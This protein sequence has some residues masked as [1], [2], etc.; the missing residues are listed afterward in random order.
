MLLH[1]SLLLHIANLVQEARDRILQASHIIMHGSPRGVETPL[2]IVSC[3][4]VFALIKAALSDYALR[5]I[6]LNPAGGMPVQ[7]ISLYVLA[8]R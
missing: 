5:A 7:Q 1:P 6:R 2:G 8:G 3:L 4:E